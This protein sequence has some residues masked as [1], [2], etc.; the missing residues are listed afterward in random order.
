MHK[1]LM[2]LFWEGISVYIIPIMQGEEY[3]LTISMHKNFTHVRSTFPL[4][5]ADKEEYICAEI[6][7][8]KINLQRLLEQNA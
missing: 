4:P 8:A 7:K 3:T 5:K 6:E 1:L 2:E